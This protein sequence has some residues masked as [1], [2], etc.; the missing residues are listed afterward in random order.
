MTPEEINELR[1]RIRDLERRTARKISRNRK[2]G[3]ELN[4]SEFDPRR[5][6]APVHRYNS[7]QLR[8][9]AGNLERFLSRRAQF[10]GGAKGTP[11]RREKWRQFEGL[12]NRY[13]AIGDTAFNQVRNV[14]LPNGMT[15]GERMASTQSEFPRTANPAV[16]SPFNKMQFHSSGVTGER[17]LAKLVKQVRDKMNP[18][19]VAKE[20]AQGREQL[21]QMLKIVGRNDIQEKVQKLNDKQFHLLWHYSNLA[22]SVSIVYEIEMA[23]LAGKDEKRWYDSVADDSFNEVDELVDWAG[24]VQYRSEQKPD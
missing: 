10:V 15:V 5:K 24:K 11:I 6:E 23:R 1:K 7:H 16:N 22:G 2:K 8:A 13:N 12:Q 19:K 18:K 20:V 14:K 17:A 4:N 21:A 9:Y 3:V